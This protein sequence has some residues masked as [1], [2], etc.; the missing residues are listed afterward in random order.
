MILVTVLLGRV[1]CAIC[2]LELVNRLTDHTVTMF[3]IPRKRAARWMRDG[4]IILLLYGVVQMMVAAVHLHRVPMYTSLYLLAMLVMAMLI[5]LFYSNRAFCQ[6][7]CPVGML[8]KLY[9]RGGMLAVRPVLSSLKADH[10]IARSCKSLLSPMRLDRSRDDD[11]LMCL[12]CI[13][14]DSEK[15]RM[16]FYLRF[17][18]TN[19]DRRQIVSGWP[20]TLFIMMVSG[21]VVYEIAGFW[22]TVKNLFLWVPNQSGVLLGLGVDNGWLNGIWYATNRYVD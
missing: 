1:W 15:G 22:P 8:L 20:V 7:L 3:G 11:C 13:Q 14:A 9:G 10:A 4:W 17:P 16:Q 18:W 19:L 2:P 5:G 6:T 21:F 12:D